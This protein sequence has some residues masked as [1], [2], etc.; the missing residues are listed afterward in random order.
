M[1]LLIIPFFTLF[2]LSPAIAQEMVD[3]NADSIDTIVLSYEISGNSSFA[4]NTLVGLINV[5]TPSHIIVMEMHRGENGVD[6]VRRYYPK[7]SS[8]NGVF[9]HQSGTYMEVKP[10]H[11]VPAVLFPDSTVTIA[12]FDC[13]LATYDLF[14]HQYTAYYTAS[15]GIKFSTT[16]D[17]PGFVFYYERCYPDGVGRYKVSS[18]KPMKVYQ[19]LLFP[20]R[21]TVKKWNYQEPNPSI[22]PL[23]T[24]TSKSKIF[25]PLINFF[26]PYRTVQGLRRKA[27][28]FEDHINIFLIIHNLN[29]QTLTLIKKLDS[30]A[31]TNK[32]NPMHFAV[33]S[34]T[35]IDK[36]IADRYPDLDFLKK[37]K[38]FLASLHANSKEGYLI[39]GPSHVNKNLVPY[40]PGNLE[41]LIDQLIEINQFHDFEE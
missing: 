26:K 17:V 33:A 36:Y 27:D 22:I 16:V 8:H 14:G 38:K 29:E 41:N 10:Q 11:N 35:T 5:V 2:L 28:F 12:G 34:Y 37:G 25:K 7:T 39:L 18:L 19:H 24:R 6:T 9:V 40:E 3:N 13:S 23:S 32:E 31:T 15:L 21:S 4:K 30:L 20:A 1:R